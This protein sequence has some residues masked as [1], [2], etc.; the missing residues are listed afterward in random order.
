MQQIEIEI[1]TLQATQA[2]FTGLAHFV[3]AGVP[4]IDFGHQRHAVAQ[5]VNR[6]AHHLFRPAVSVHFGGIDNRQP[7]LNA[8]SQ[9]SH[10]LRTM[11][12]ALP[13]IPGSLP[14]GGNRLLVAETAHFYAHRYLL[15]LLHHRNAKQGIT[16]CFDAQ[17]S[18]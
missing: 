11:R 12:A 3:P 10:F 7:E 4:G 16:P 8:R 18:L 13:H 14:D 6:L 5:A 2:G 9:C 15:S 1:I 17:I